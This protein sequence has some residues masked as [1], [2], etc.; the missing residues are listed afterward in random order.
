[1]EVIMVHV[2][3]RIKTKIDLLLDLIILELITHF[4]DLNH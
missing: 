2:P 4:S 1:M 3:I